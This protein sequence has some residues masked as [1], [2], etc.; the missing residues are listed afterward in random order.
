MAAT[1]YARATSGVIYDEEEEGR[2]FSP[3]TALDVA[4]DLERFLPE[5]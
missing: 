4:R 5:L 2:L 1:A 3:A